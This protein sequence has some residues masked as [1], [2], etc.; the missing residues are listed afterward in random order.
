MHR[1]S[2]I[3]A[4]V[5][6]LDTSSC[7]VKVVCLIADEKSLRER[8]SADI[9][10]GVRTADIIDRSIA[11]IP[12]YRSLNAVQID[13]SNKTVRMITEEIKQSDLTAY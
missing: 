11:K 12:L 6:R 1:Q 4:I 5:E 3:D 8:L 2:I 9:K 7:R 13:T 10:K